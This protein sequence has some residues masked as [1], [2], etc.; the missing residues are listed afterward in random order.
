MC[1][2]W[3]E[4]KSQWFIINGPQVLTWTG[5]W[6]MQR[7]GGAALG[8]SLPWRGASRSRQPLS[9][10]R[11]PPGLQHTCDGAAL[12]SGPCCSRFIPPWS[13]P[14]ARL[15]ERV[16]RE[17]VRG[18]APSSPF[19]GEGLPC[20]ESWK[21]CLAWV[22]C[23]LLGLLKCS[24]HLANRMFFTQQLPK[25]KSGFDPLAQ[26]PAFFSFLIDV[27]MIAQ[28]N[29]SLGMNY[30]GVIGSRQ[31]ELIWSEEFFMETE[32]LSANPGLSY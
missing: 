5:R 1:I 18:P 13:L 12:L 21:H 6:F 3:A 2:G 23:L 10:P 11:P 25:A 14:E 9:Q 16:C 31:G 8:V 20:E 30:A 22:I 19:P 7:Q 15:G 29:L 4:F 26:F 28:S 27:E 17:G 24:E 32:I